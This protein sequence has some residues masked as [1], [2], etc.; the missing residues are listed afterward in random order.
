MIVAARSAEA[1]DLHRLGAASEL[2]DQ[3]IKTMPAGKT[4]DGSD[5]LEILVYP[6][7]QNG[8]RALSE[9]PFIPVEDLITARPNF[10]VSRY[11]PA[12]FR[13]F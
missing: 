13:T 11:F 7:G 5:Q 4:Q 12:S 6:A 1:R 9:S 3:R 8:S 2:P 10:S